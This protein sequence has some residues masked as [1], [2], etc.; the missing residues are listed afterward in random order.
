M[1]NQAKVCRM[2]WREEPREGAVSCQG[3]SPKSNFQKT[4]TSPGKGREESL[5]SESKCSLLRLGG[6]TLKL[7][8]QS[9]ERIPGT[10]LCK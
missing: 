9:N 5:D 8:P 10:I 3:F 4:V 6:C 7:H 2:Q 1:F